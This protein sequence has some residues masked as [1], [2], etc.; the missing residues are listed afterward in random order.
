MC[1][2][3][4]LSVVRENLPPPRFGSPSIGR[5]KFSIQNSGALSTTTPRLDWDLTQP[6]SSAQL[7]NSPPPHTAPRFGLPHLLTILYTNTPDLFQ[8]ENTW[9]PIFVCARARGWGP[10]PIVTLED[11]LDAIYVYFNTPLSVCDQAAM[12]DRAW[13]HLCDVYHH[14]FRRAELSGIELCLNTALFARFGIV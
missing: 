13:Q 2:A 1:F 7:Y 9:G 12:S 5:R 6:T 10:H 8:W 14:R 11:V 4:T 3:T